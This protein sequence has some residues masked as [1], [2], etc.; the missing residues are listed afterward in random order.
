MRFDEDRGKNVN[1]SK[2]FNINLLG[3]GVCRGGGECCSRL[4]HLR[5]EKLA[6][7]E[8]GCSGGCIQHC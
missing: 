1:F 3:L 7:H 8:G 4:D 5:L 6:V 2:V